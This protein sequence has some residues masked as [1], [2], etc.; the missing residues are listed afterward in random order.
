M[1]LKRMPA[2]SY[3]AASSESWWETAVT[4][5]PPGRSTPSDR[6]AASPPIVSST[7]SMS[8]TASVKSAAANAAP[9]QAWS[10]CMPV[11]RLDVLLDMLRPVPLS[12]FLP[13]YTA[14]GFFV[15]PGLLAQISHDDHEAVTAFGALDRGFLT[16]L[17]SQGI[18]WRR[19]DG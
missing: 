18:R 19:F 12:P 9:H 17:L 4:R 6:P 14:E 7:T 1:P 16:P 3:L 5:W 15:A 13:A 2:A 11:G 8:R 10:Y